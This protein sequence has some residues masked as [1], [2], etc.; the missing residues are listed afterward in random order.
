MRIQKLRTISL[1]TKLVKLQL[2]RLFWEL[3]GRGT[4][5]RAIVIIYFVDFSDKMYAKLSDSDVNMI[6]KLNK[7]N[8]EMCRIGN[9][10]VYIL[11]RAH[12]SY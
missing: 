12:V 7:C 11:F 5:P 8:E 9:E 6:L 4:P 1:L 2:A 3:L 10:M